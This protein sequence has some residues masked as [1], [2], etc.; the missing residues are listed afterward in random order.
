MSKDA[1][2]RFRCSGELKNRLKALAKAK[3]QDL[4][5]YV[6]LRVLE[7]VE[8][9]EGASPSRV[10]RPAVLRTQAHGHEESQQAKRA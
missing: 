10:D 3:E 8:R 6:R 4:S 9:E 7:I 1:V 5:D 2:I